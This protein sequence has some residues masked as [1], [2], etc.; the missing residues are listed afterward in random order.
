[1]TMTSINIL[2]EGNEIT[3]DLLGATQGSKKCYYIAR[4]ANEKVGE[5][6]DLNGNNE[7]RFIE[8]D[9]ILD[10][11]GED[12][13]FHKKT[14]DEEEY[15]CPIVVKGIVGYWLHKKDYEGTKAI[16]DGY[17]QLC[18]W[19][20]KKTHETDFDAWKRDLQKEFVCYHHIPT[21]KKWIKESEALFEFITESDQKT[22]KR[23]MES[24]L[25][26]ANSKRIKLYPEEGEQNVNGSTP[27]KQ[28]KPGRKKTSFKDFIINTNESDRVIALINKH[29]KKEQPKQIAL[30]IIGGIETG[31]IREDVS[32]P[33]IGLEFG[34]K[35]DSVK[36]HLCKYRTTRGK[37]N[38]H[39]SDTELKP[40]KDIFLKQK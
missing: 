2:F 22:V 20:Y 26:Y 40:F 32:A 30:L 31:K 36:P 17:Y 25:E 1:M 5:I 39:F 28:S 15:S 35:G 7:Y 29:I 4:W 14:K 11:N 19:E 13:H 23:I 9:Y 27:S 8:Y 24:Y 6:V 16:F 34:V 10:V 33:S 18:L 12:K 3:S 21:E 38:P 37:L